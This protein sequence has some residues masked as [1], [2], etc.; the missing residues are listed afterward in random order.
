MRAFAENL[1]R[2]RHLKGWTQFFL[3]EKADVTQEEISLWERGRRLPTLRTL[4]RLAEALR[5]PSERLPHSPE[6][7]SLSR[8]QI[9]RIAR[10][11]LLRAGFKTSRGLTSTEQELAQRVGALVIQ[12]LRSHGVPGRRRYDRSRWKVSRRAMEV[13]QL[14]G[15]GPV[16]QILHR[17]D[18]LLAMGSWR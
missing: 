16:T 12:K 13:K 18:K 14:F 9:D 17:V 2:W 5:I 7:V 15:E 11:I 8:E 1:I 3:A 6:T 10:V 4:N